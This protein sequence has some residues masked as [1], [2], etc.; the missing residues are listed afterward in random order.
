MPPEL[1]KERVVS[2][3]TK[4]ITQQGDLANLPP[5]LAPLMERPQWA[6]WRWTQLPNGKW[7]KPPFMA[8]QPDRHVSTNDPSTWSD[9]Q[10]ALAAV[11]TGHGDGISYVLT[12][13]DPFGATDLDHCRCATTYSIDTWAQNWLDTGR[14]TYSEIT[15]SG[16]GIRQWGFAKG[17][18]VNKKYTLT[19]DDNGV[20]AE[21]F[22][23]TNQ[24]L[25][26]TG[27]TLDPAIKK[28]GR[29]DKLIGWG[30]TWGERRKAAA[31]QAKAPIGGNGFD[32]TGSK[33]SIE[34]I[35]EIIRT[36]APAGADRSGVFHAVVGHFVGCGWEADRILEHMSQ[37]PDGIGGR[38]LREDRLRQEI[39]RS[40][41]KYSKPIEL[42]LSGLGW[43]ADWEAKA[44]PE[45]E[46]EQKHKEPPE[47]EEVRNPPV[48][49]AG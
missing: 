1:Q 20:A 29:I 10:T 13:D 46:P 44:P 33:Y 26:V 9:Y 18:P 2:D 14:D 40:A 30:I 7:Q 24:V 6:I 17:D 25:T 36:G 12:A 28:L 47:Q 48:K 8:T 21:L 27:L 42:P 4:P 32:S 45:P 31:A 16:Q 15:P 22:R 41:G 34:Q 37:Y 5:A 38:Y 35:E 11:Q 19:I 43:S 23:K 3:T 49:A 39:A